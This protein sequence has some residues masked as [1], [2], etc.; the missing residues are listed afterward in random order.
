MTCRD[1]TT[2]DGD[3]NFDPKQE[4]SFFFFQGVGAG[5]CVCTCLKSGVR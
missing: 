5:M 1:Q 3:V 4:C 2:D